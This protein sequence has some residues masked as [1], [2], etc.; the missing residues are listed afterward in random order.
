MSEGKTVLSRDDVMDRIAEM[1][2]DLQAAATFPDGTKRATSRPTPSACSADAASATTFCALRP[3]RVMVGPR[4][5]AGPCRTDP[6]TMNPLEYLL[7]TSLGQAQAALARDPQAQLLAGGMTLIPV[8]KHRLAAPSLLVDIGRLPEL[9]QLTV[10]A[11][12]VLLGAGLSH[13]QVA[14]SARLQQALPGLASLAAGIGDAQVRARGTLGGSIANND[15]AADYPAALLALKAVVITQ[16]RELPAE[17]FFT[18]M[19]ST[20]LAQ[21]EIVTGV[22][23]AIP[24]RSAY[25]KFGH[26]ASGYAMAGVYAADFGAGDRRVAVTGATACAC[27]WPAAEAAWQQGLGSASLDHPDLLDDLHAPAAYRAQLARLMF[28]QALQTLN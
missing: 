15:P 16:R 5:S 18:G 24:R 10:Q 8:L 19:F 12:Q 6:Q 17:D 4:R 25:A 9:Q 28:E 22:R 7:A 26:P 14:A 1:I 23:F 20:A 13:R 27:R 21:G 11:D 3:A 2:P